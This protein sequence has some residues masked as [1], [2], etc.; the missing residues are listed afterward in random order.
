M[1]THTHTLTDQKAKLRREALIRRAP[2][3]ADRADSAGVALA[4]RF[5]TALASRLPGSTVSLYAPMR[6]EIDTGAL[7]AALALAGARTALP[8][9]A[10]ADAALAFSIWAPGDALVD[11]AFGVSEPA[12]DAPAVVPDIVAVPLLGFDAQGNRLGY[13]GGYYDRT[14]RALRADGE[15]I[16]VGICYDEQEFPVLPGHAGDERLDMIITDRRTIVAGV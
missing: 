13:G 3:H 7:F 16:A 5:C 9:M 6:D 15:I 14:L 10:G 11:A 12:T 1:A 2:A 8:V 4:G